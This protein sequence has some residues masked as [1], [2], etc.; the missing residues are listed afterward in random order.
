MR[1]I[2]TILLVICL[3]FTFAAC[4]PATSAKKTI[5]IDFAWLMQDAM[6]SKLWT[7]VQASAAAYNTAHPET[8]V[9][10][11]MLNAESKVDKELANVEA[12]IVQKPD[13]IVIISTDTKGSIPAYDAVKKAGIKCVMALKMADTTEFDLKIIGYD[14]YK[15]GQLQAESLEKYI[16]ANP[17]VNLKIGY[18]DIDPAVTDAVGRYLGFKENFL[19][20]HKTDGRAEEV[21]HVSGM[22]KTDVSMAAVEDWFQAHPDLNCVVAANDLMA[23]GAIEAAKGAKKDLLVLGM[24]GMDTALQAIKDGTLL[25]SVYSDANKVGDGL[26]NECLKVALGTQTQKE[27]NLG[28]VSLITVD[29]SNVDQYLTVK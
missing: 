20:K 22:W 21:A 19:D 8:N 24:D 17:S 6:M 1:K 29:K 27:V 14:H 18:L 13:V 4:G 3:I 12:F 16:Q 25:M 5:T 7:T 26:F 23:M 2:A 15:A 9:V 11:N 28:T 10:V